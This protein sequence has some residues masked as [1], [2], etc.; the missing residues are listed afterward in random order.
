MPVRAA[1]E[2]PVISTLVFADGKIIDTRQANAVET[3]LVELPVF[4]AIGAEP[5]SG[6]VAPL[7]G[8]PDRDAVARERPELFDQTIIEFLRPLTFEEPDDFVSAGHEL[9]AIPPARVE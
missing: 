1:S 3:L 7:V 6:R 2:R 9:G 8:K 5:I 4:V